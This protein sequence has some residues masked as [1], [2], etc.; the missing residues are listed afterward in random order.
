MGAKTMAIVGAGPG[1][2]LALAKRFGREGFQL[3]LL[4]RNP[5]KLDDMLTE[6]RGSGLTAEGFQADVTQADALKAAF[7][8]AEERFGEINM[9]EYSAVTIPADFA[10]FAPLGVTG[11]TADTARAQFEVMTLGAVAT[12][13]QVLPA[14]QARGEGAIVITTGISAI[15]YMPM[16][17]AW[18]IAGAGARNYARTLN[19]ALKDSGVFVG[20]ICLGVQIAKGDEHGDPDKLADIYYDFMQKRD[21]PELVINHIPAGSITFD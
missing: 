18:G 21:Q 13:Q 3:A 20:T 12:V 2:G 8:A 6:L 1:L 19:V 9:V 11:M 16:V 17:G 4:A 10:G 7:A 5:K 15:G 14:M